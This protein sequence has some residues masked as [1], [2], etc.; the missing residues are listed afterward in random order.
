VIIVT[1]VPLVPE[2]V[3]TGA[4]SEVNAIASP[5]LAVPTTVKVF[6]APIVRLTIEVKVIVWAVRML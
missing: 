1:V 2:V 6:V 4:V 5:L 3:Q